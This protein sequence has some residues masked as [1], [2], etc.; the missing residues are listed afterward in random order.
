MMVAG[1]A[2]RIVICGQILRGGDP[3]LRALLCSAWVGPWGVGQTARRIPCFELDQ[4]CVL[5]LKYLIGICISYVCIAVTKILDKK[6][7]CRESQ[8]GQCLVM[9]TYR[10]FLCGALESREHPKLESRLWL[11]GVLLCSEWPVSVYSLGTST[12]NVSV[13]EMFQIQSINITNCLRF[14]ML[15]VLIIVYTL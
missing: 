2:I 13:T 15:P 7:H 11:Q 6:P 14:P 4:V 10:L 9:G 1:C 12:W 8:V 3:G 5:H